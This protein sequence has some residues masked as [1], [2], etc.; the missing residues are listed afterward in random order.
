MD[1]MPRVVIFYNLYNLTALESTFIV[2]ETF[3]QFPGSGGV[4]T[5]ALGAGVR[6]LGGQ[7]QLGAVTA[8]RVCLL[9][10][11]AKASLPFALSCRPQP[12]AYSNKSVLKYFFN[13][14]SSFFQNCYLAIDAL[15][16]RNIFTVTSQWT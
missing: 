2:S 7:L 8:P 5:T 12:I 3:I 13:S 16:F 11:E 4:R 6:M 15:K 10:Y 9:Q 1:S 14:I